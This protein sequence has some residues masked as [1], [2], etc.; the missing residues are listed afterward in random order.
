MRA[1]PVTAVPALL[2]PLECRAA[3]ATWLRSSM[4]IGCRRAE[5]G[6]RNVKRGRDSYI[7]MWE[8]SKSLARKYCGAGAVVRGAG[9]RRR[10][11]GREAHA[12]RIQWCGPEHKHACPEGAEKE[13]DT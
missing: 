5:E 13:L 9:T 2:V 3:A 1:R 8:P 7:W 6:R 12:C 10:G 4:E 11:L